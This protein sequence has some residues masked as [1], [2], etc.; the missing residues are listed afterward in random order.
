MCF[1][2]KTSITTFIIGTG[3]NIYLYQLTNNINVKLIALLW[4][5]SL[6]MQLLDFLTW[7]SD[8]PSRQQTI[9]TRL[10]YIFNILQPIAILLFAF[11]LKNDLSFSEKSIGTFLAFFYL[12]YILVVGYFKKNQAKD[13]IKNIN[14]CKHVDY[15]WWK[16]NKY[17]GVLYF[18][19]LYVLTI[20]FIKPF[21]FAISQLAYITITF[22]LSMTFYNCGIPS[23]WCFFQVLAPLYTILTVKMMKL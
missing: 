9:S 18:I 20:L 22:L 15:Y 4:Q 3:L 14:G 7:S 17:L 1:D 12:C 13:C 2:A 23:I 11:I 19:V 16:D 8:C 10:S 6:S 21:K 5:F